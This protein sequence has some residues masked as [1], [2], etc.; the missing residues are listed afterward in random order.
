MFK[1]LV[2]ILAQQVALVLRDE[3]RTQ[4]IRLYKEQEIKRLL[5]LHDRARNEF[6]R[7]K[8]LSELYE[9]TNGEAPKSDSTLSS[10]IGG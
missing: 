5:R 4:V 10:D 9:F 7:D 2:T 1:W 6:D 3:V 8:F